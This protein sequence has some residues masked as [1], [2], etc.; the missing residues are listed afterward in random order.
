[1]LSASL[2]LPLLQ[3]LL[4]EVPGD[5]VLQAVQCAL[6]QVV[7]RQHLQLSKQLH[8]EVRPVLIVCDESGHLGVDGVSQGIKH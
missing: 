7:G 5:Q 1:M 2:S 4:S 3:A 8:Q 6:S